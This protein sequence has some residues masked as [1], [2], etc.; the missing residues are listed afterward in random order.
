M[1][2][3]PCEYIFWHGLPVLR[4]EIARSMINDF[5]LSQ[6][7]AAHKMG[8][9]VVISCKTGRT[10]NVCVEYECLVIEGAVE[11]GC[12]RTVKDHRWNRCQCG[13]L[14]GAPVI[15]DKEGRKMEDGHQFSN[16]SCVTRQVYARRILA[17]RENC[18]RRFS[19][20]FQT[21]HTNCVSPSK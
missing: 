2:Q 12:L 11:R 21:N 7:E 8:F 3:T 6:K 16:R 9:P 20:P 4:K 17:V 10:C 15:G 1:K 13:K 5:G 19:I 18:P 14:S